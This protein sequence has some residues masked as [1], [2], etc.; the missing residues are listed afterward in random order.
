MKVIKTLH[1]NCQAETNFHKIFEQNFGII[2]F[3]FIEI[4]FNSSVSHTKTKLLHLEIG[5]LIFTQMF[6]LLIEII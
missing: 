5:A 1:V 6:N 3:E 2:N 4:F